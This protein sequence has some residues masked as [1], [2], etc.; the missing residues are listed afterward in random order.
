MDN[1]KY[2]QLFIEESEEYIHLMN[3]CILALE[4]NADDIDAINQFYRGA[5]SIKGMAATMGYNS[6]KDVAHELESIFDLVKK[7]K[8]M[9]EI[10][11]FNVIFEGIDILK[12]SIEL[13][14]NKKQLP[15]YADYREKIHSITVIQELDQ[16]E[17]V[18]SNTE[19]NK[20][21]EIDPRAQ[22]FKYKY[23]IEV[24]ITTDSAFP[25]ARA[26]V[27]YS[28]FSTAGHITN[29]YPPLEDI[30]KGKPCHFVSFDFIADLN[31][32]DIEKILKEISDIEHFGVL[33]VPFETEKKEKEFTLSAET[34]QITSTLKIDSKVLDSIYNSV[35]ELFILNEEFQEYK[36][37]LP[38]SLLKTSTDFNLLI[39]QLFEDIS[40]ARLLPFGA[41]LSII[42]R[43]V[44]D[45]SQKEGK[46]VKLISK[47][48][49]I[50]IDKAIL[51]HL[52]DPLVH[53]VRNAI[54]H[55]IEKPEERIQN[56]KSQ[57]GIISINA[58][59]ES[60]HLKVTI[61]DD[62]KGI[63]VK[64]IREVAAKKGIVSEQKVQQ[65]TPE[66]V[67]LLITL[68]GFS[69]VSA[70]SEISGRGYGMDIVKAKI[71]SIGGD[72]KVETKARIGTKIILTVPLT[73]SIADTFIVSIDG[74]NFAVPMSPIIK[75]MCLQ[76]DEIHYVQSE[77][78]IVI[79]G[80]PAYLKFLSRVLEIP[81]N[82]I[83][84]DCSVLLVEINEKLKGIIVDEVVEQRRVI[85]K[86]LNSPLEMLTYYQGAAILSKGRILPV[87]DI[88]KILTY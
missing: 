43:M 28:K 54:D 82:S 57:E 17:P 68:P 25:A 36:N 6:M 70:V 63:D 61:I 42:P 77:P 86:S 46:I 50:L 22:D 34:K 53:I 51:E 49:D 35:T 20:S 40:K 4:K 66:E 69:T 45:L 5:H 59:R 27:I 26:M 67:L 75:T 31:Q 9:F 79:D 60:G 23:R 16:N 11:L 18:V 74:N 58:Q 39:S 88:L 44:R 38:Y 37:Q 56:G 83:R 73:V 52:I 12:K 7:K 85:V 8:L 84:K 64:R 81:D 78:C 15:D 2:L 24:N 32:S 47:G 41:V 13:V 30:A 65:M 48:E 29:Y 10:N 71:E 19:N 3:D 1:D 33:L 21:Q 76:K 14:G 80:N 87:I 55:G 72:I 62:G